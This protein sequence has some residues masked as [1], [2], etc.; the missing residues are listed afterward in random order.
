V[1]QVQRRRAHAIFLLANR[2]TSPELLAPLASP[3]AVAG[4]VI[5]G[6]ASPD[7]EP[8]I[9]LA[10]DAKAD[11]RAYDAFEKEPRPNR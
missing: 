7:F 2:D 9:A 3:D 11:R 1:A 8:D 6:A 5:L 10:V 4:L